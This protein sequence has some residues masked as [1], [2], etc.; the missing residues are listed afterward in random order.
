MAG[1]SPFPTE[2]YIYIHMINIFTLVLCIYI[3]RNLYI[4]ISTN[5]VEYESVYTGIR[6]IQFS[7]LNAFSRSS[8]RMFFLSLLLGDG[9]MRL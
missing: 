5:A 8:Q 3:Y 7:S 4:C 1:N 2:I 9:K 6:H